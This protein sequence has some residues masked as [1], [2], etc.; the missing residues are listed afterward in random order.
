MPKIDLFWRHSV[1]TMRAKN[2][3]PAIKAECL[4]FTAVTNSKTKC[5][6]EC[7]PV[8]FYKENG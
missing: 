7:N 8:T 5:N 2:K 1:K 3:H 4:F 6:L